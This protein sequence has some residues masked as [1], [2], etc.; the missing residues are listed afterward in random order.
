MEVHFIPSRKKITAAAV[1]VA[2]ACSTAE[3]AVAGRCDNGGSKKDKEDEQPQRKASGCVDRSTTFKERE[4]AYGNCSRSSMWKNRKEVRLYR[5][6][7]GAAIS[8]GTPTMGSTT[9]ASGSSF[10]IISCINFPFLE[11]TQC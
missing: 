7:E 5:D 9:C 1:P 8:K 4:N 11:C 6:V 3:T 2:S 10:D